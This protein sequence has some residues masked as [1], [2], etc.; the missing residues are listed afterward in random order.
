VG[1]HE[2]FVDDFS[3]PMGL[4]GDKA[5]GEGVKGNKHTQSKAARIPR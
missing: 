4:D 3:N 5:R 1:G 2:A